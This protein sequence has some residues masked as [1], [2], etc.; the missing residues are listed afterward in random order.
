MPTEPEA[1]E[2]PEM[3]YLTSSIPKDT[4]LAAVILRPATPSAMRGY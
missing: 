2:P 3:I 1:L 4:L